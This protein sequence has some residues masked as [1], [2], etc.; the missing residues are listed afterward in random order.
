[1]IRTNPTTFHSTFFTFHCKGN[2]VKRITLSSAL[3]FL[4]LIIWS[5]PAFAS[6]NPLVKATVTDVA[7]K[8]IKG[9]YIFFYD[10]PNTKRA[11]D[12]VSTVTDK[13]GY[14]EKAV[15]PGRYW[16]L[17]RLKARGNF[18]MGPLMIEDKF[19]GDPLEIEVV[20]GEELTL[21]FTVMDLLDTIITKTKKR[22]DLNKVSGR[23]VNEKGE[24][25]EGVFAFANRHKSSLTVPDFFSAWTESDGAFVIYLPT[26]KYN[27]GAAASFN[28]KQRYKAEQEI[29][30]SAALENLKIVLAGPINKEVE[31]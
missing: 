13:N 29:S 3:I 6:N 22:E 18:D 12:L 21:D 1:M 10:S 17:A 28:P 5:S 7:G 11:V 20:V 4:F 2:F 8:P 27:L 14:C 26:G 15:P 30:V 23:V 31:K 25:L 19:S 24:A 9:A 16:V